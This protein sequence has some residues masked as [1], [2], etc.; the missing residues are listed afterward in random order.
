MQP[1]AEPLVVDGVRESLAR[2]GYVDF[3]ALFRRNATSLDSQVE[4][5]L[6]E[7]LQGEECTSSVFDSFATICSALASRFL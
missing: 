5:V 1:V 2:R 7:T 4:F 6:P 3:Q